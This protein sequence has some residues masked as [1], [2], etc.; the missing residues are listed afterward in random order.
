VISFTHDGLELWYATND[1]PAPDGTVEDRAGIAITVGVRPAKPGN[2]VRVHYRVDGRNVRSVAA[3]LVRNEPFQGRQYFRARLPPIWS[4]DTVDYIPVVTSAGRRV[5]DPATALTFPSSFR[6]A[7]STFSPV[8]PTAPAEQRR[9]FPVRTAYIGTSHVIMASRP[10][11]IG[12][13]PAGFVINWAP[14][15]GTFIGPHLR[16]SVH[17]QGDHELIVR[18]DGVGDLSVRV[19]LETDDHALISMRYS[20]VVDLGPDG[21]ERARQQRWPAVSQVRSAPRL[22]TSNAEYEWL[23][24]LQCVGIGEVRAAELRYMYDLYALE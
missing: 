14:A 10:D 18:T 19:T 2:T 13:T 9:G 16:A 3:P 21:A 1:A 11:V 24:R 22:L 4:G 5:P 20:A 23:N 15:G 12:E 8:P 17:S 6:L 7:S